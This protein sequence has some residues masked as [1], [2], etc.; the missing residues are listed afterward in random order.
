MRERYWIGWGSCREN[1]GDMR[2][3]LGVRMKM[4]VGSLRDWPGVRA[5][6]IVG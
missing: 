1:E 6:M 2:G 4:M 3:R 5:E